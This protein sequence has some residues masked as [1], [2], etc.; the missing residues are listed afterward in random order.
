VAPQRLFGGCN[1]LGKLVEKTGHLLP[2][3]SNGRDAANAEERVNDDR[4]HG[5]WQPASL[6]DDD[7]RL[8]R[9]GEQHADQHRREQPHAFA[10]DE[11]RAGAGD[12]GRREGWTLT[13]PTGK[14]PPT[15]FAAGTSSIEVQDLQA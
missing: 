10:D 15:V 8:E 6:E 13:R 11:K 5:P 3:N 7:E 9:V 4:R 2:R 12:D 1:R 14:P